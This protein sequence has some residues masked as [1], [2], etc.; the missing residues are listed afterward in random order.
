MILMHK[1]D[2]RLCVNPDHLQAGTHKEN[3]ADMVSKGRSA[4]GERHGNVRVTVDIVRDI[5]TRGLSIR[6]YSRKYGIGVTTVHD[7]VHRKRWAHVE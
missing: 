7:I 6:A 2:N 1:C 4:Y 5:R 3:T